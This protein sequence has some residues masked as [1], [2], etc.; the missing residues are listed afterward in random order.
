MHPNLQG[1]WRPSDTDPEIDPDDAPAVIADP[2]RHPDIVQLKEAA[3]NLCRF[4]LPHVTLGLDHE[5]PEL[6]AWAVARAIGPVKRLAGLEML[7]IK[8]E[9]VTVYLTRRVP[10]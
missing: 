3:A 6:W 5:H 7:R 1:G 2:N 9:D 4:R 10:S 8:L